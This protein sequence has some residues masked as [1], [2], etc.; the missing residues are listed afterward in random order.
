MSEK[1]IADVVLANGLS[2]KFEFE[3]GCEGPALFVLGIRKSGSSLLNSL[4][5][6][7]ARLNSRH[8]LDIGGTFFDNNILF[9]DWG[10]DPAWLP[11]IQPTN[12]YGGFRVMP[13]ALSKLE[14]FITGPKI[15]MV[16]DPRDALVS[17]YFSSAYSHSI[18]V[19]AEE[20]DEVTN[21]MQRERS[22]ALNSVIDEFVR[23]RAFNIGQHL[24]GYVAVSRMPTT[25]LL[26][27]EDWIFS[28]AA[29]IRALSTHLNLP[30]DDETI[31]HM[32]SWS[33]V[34]PDK[35]DPK[36]FVRKVT[37]GDHREKLKPATIRELNEV[38]RPA[39]EE[40]GYETDG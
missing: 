28:K 15:L 24:K 31:G 18:P 22:A 30:V 20:R 13:T 14:L 17:E 1:T 3:V 37:P 34:R 23:S 2:V 33:D 7:L 40:Y 36:A 5:G 26:R 29:L 21:A 35:E 25:L 16:R 32:V 4:C 38:L 11:V 8:F 10:D 12:V 9:R 39:M 6:E 27:Y 19:V